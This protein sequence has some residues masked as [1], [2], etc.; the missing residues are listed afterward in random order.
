MQTK[1]ENRIVNQIKGKL[2]TNKATI[3]KADKCNSIVI[4]YQDDYNIKVNNFILNSNFR[5]ANSDINKTNYNGTLGIL[6]K[7][8]NKAY[9]RTTAPTIRGL[10]KIHKE[11]APVRPV[12]NWKNAPAYKLTKI[13]SKEL[14]AYIALP[15]TF[16]VK[17]IATDK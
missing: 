4:L 2:N 6:S 5:V 11:G 12:I 17:N 13:L 1:D 15:Y 3:Y 9:T 10:V 16:D 7:T 8:A 14:Q